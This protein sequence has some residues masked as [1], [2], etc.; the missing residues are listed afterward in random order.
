MTL[1]QML[2][3]MIYVVPIMAVLIGALWLVI[4][5]Q[6]K[7]KE[8]LEAALTQEQKD[9]LLQTQATPVQEDQGSFVIEA[10]VVELKEWVDREYADGRTTALSNEELEDKIAELSGGKLGRVI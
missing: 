8:A 10:L 1:T 9:R 6:N 4:R 3:A 7:T 5:K 2:E